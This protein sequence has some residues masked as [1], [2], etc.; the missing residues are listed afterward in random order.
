[1]KTENKLRL[2][3]I[4]RILDEETD[5]NQYLTTKQIMDLLKEK[6][7]LSVYRMTVSSD[8]DLMIEAGIDIQC[9]HSTQNRYHLVS[10]PFELDIPEPK[11]LIDA[12]ISAKFITAKKSK[13]LIS[14]IT[15]LSGEKHAEELKR[16]LYI[17]ENY[18]TENEQVYLIADAI[19]E[20]KR[21]TAS[22]ALSVRH[23]SQW[24]PTH[25][26]LE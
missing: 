14:R 1:M 26:T 15:A 25:K 8:I 3:Y 11:M 22:T 23:R 18:K 12:V 24:K 10:R 16:N 7:G 21:I 5:E 9:T 13:E 6:Y 2:L 4:Y 19:N 17:D 20:A